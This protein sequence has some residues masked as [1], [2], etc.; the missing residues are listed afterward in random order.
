M[1]YEQYRKRIRKKEINGQCHK[2]QVTDED[3]TKAP[4]TPSSEHWSN[5]LTALTGY[6]TQQRW[7]TT[8]KQ[9]EPNGLIALNSY[10]SQQ[11]VTRWQ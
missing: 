5:R 8:E 3:I 10:F 6:C 7:H 4:V 2:K 9:A 11:N 1:L